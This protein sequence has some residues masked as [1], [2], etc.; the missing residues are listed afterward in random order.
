M[1]EKQSKKISSLFP[2]RGSHNAKRAD[3]P[4]NKITQGKT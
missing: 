2:K 1:Y 3:K 4:K